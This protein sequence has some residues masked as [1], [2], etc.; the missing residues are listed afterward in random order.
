MTRP[1]NNSRFFVRR[2][3]Y[4]SALFAFGMVCTAAGIWWFR[5]LTVSM[6]APAANFVA[7][8]AIVAMV[9]GTTVITAMALV[10]KFDRN[11]TALD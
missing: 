10:G 2:L 6:N 7:G 4:A 1:S 9:V 11:I 3:K 8:V 5:W